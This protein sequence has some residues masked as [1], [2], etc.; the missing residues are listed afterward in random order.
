MKGFI[1][2]SHDDY[3]PCQEFKKHLKAVEREF[4]ITFWS[5][6]RISAGYVWTKEIADAIAAA[7]VCLVLTSAESIASDYIY[8]KELP[9]MQKRHA[10]GAL[11]IPVVQR[12]C[13]W[14]LVAGSLQAVPTVE[15]RLQPIEDFRRHNDGYDRAREQIAA[16]IRRHFGLASGRA[17]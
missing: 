2:Y 12:K 4:G 9:E 3:R 15:G 14:Q 16:A 10:A 1:S 5:D 17:S 7:D 13:Q 11:L 6:E 8:F